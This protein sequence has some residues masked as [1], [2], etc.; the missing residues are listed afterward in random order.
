MRERALNKSTEAP[1]RV[2][3]R[4]QSDFTGP[5]GASKVAQAAWK[6]NANI[7]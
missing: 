2:F 4:H 1:A 6:K 7:V 3:G 5:T